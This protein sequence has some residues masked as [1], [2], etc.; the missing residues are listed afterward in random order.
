MAYRRKPLP[1]ATVKCAVSG[2]PDALEQAL[3]F[4][5]RYLFKL[6]LREYTDKN[7]LA[8][9]YF[10]Y[11]VFSELQVFLMEKILAFDVERQI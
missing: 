6:S 1:Y 5:H 2:D 7:G 11:T 4:Y 3:R 8:Q 9:T 10:D